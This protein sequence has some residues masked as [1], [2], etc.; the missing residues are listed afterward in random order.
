MKE[1]IST[2]LLSK[3]VNVS[4]DADLP[5]PPQSEK[6]DYGSL[7]TLVLALYRLSTEL[8]CKCLGLCSNSSVSGC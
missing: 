8:K 5:A 2:H 3:G 6:K 4:G 1:V 7:Q